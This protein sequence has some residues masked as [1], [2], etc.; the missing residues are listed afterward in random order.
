M[1]QP[2]TAGMRKAVLEDDQRDIGV[3][4]LLHTAASLAQN[5]DPGRFSTA[6]YLHQAALGR[7]LL[8]T[9]DLD[10][11]QTG[12]S[13][14]SLNFHEVPP[15]CRQEAE[16]RIRRAVALGEPY[17]PDEAVDGPQV[18]VAFYDADRD[19]GLFADRV[20]RELG[21][22]A[23]FFPV[24][25]TTL[26]T[27]PR[28]SDDDLARIA[29]HHEL[30]YHTATHRSAR[31]ITARNQESEVRAPIERLTRAAGRPPRLAAWRGGARF[32]AGTLGDQLLRDLGVRHLV[33]N[34][35]IEPVG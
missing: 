17:D 21:V 10:G 19:T 20:C 34:W 3:P 30:C 5:L 12:A 23:Y 9:G 28:L 31:E 14:L 29:E 8:E 2:S 6:G 24:D 33:S 22:R 13:L 35:S 32:D 26:E 27:G 1:T 16:D 7:R 18:M 25:A 15:A 11:E 4:M